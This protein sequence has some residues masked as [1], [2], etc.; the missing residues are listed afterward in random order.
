[1][2]RSLF[3]FLTAQGGLYEQTISFETPVTFGGHADA[4]NMQTTAAKRFKVSIEF[5]NDWVK[6]KRKAG[7]LSQNV[8]AKPPLFAGTCGF[9]SERFERSEI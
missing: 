9:V 1:L 8:G 2:F 5:V 3:L 6:L 7:S 4:G